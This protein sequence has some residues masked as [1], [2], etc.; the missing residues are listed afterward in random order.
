[1]GEKHTSVWRLLVGASLALLLGCQQSPPPGP[2][3]APPQS[4]ASQ[5]QGEGDALAA[6]GDYA[7]A[8]VKY[9]AAVSR[10]ADDVSLHFALGVALSHLDRR[11]ETIEQFRWVV[12]RGVPG[13]AEVQAARRW[14]VAAGELGETAPL[15][16]SASSPMAEPAAAEP[17]ST[18]KLMGKTE[19]SGETSEVNLALTRL[20]KL[21][22][23][24][25]ASK[26]VKLGEPYEFDGVLPGGY[27]L[28]A[29]NPATGTVLWDL[30]V[31]VTAKQ[32]TTLDLTSANRKP[33]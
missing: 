24:P 30:E 23:E 13:S 10:E 8:A 32:E 18:G 27:R 20:N 19:A 12:T 25:T 22:G 2:V 7:A 29:Q 21:G 4:P 15:A 3:N 16:S 5:L 17:P 28:T 1:M 31:T 14:L 9:Q 26:T 11:G 33:Q 6:R